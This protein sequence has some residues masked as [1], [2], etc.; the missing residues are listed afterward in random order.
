[1]HR[2]F[3]LSLFSAAAVLSSAATP[4]VAAEDDPYADWSVT[5]LVGEAESVL[6]QAKTDNIGAESRSRVVYLAAQRLAKS[7]QPHRAR[8][9]FEKG[10]QLSPWQIE[11][12]LDYAD[13]LKTL[14]ED[15][16][17]RH[18][19]EHVVELSETEELR[20]R[21]AEWLGVAPEPPLTVLDD[22]LIPLGRPAICIIPVGKPP[23][24]LVN[25]CGY[26]LSAILGLE[27][28][29]Y[30]D[31]IALPPSNRSALRRWANQVGNDIHWDHPD[32][33][34][35]MGRL[36][37]RPNKERIIS[38]TDV[39][40]VMEAILQD[41]GTP[42]QLG[43][44]RKAWDRFKQAGQDEQ[45]DAEKLREHVLAGLGKETN[46]SILWVALTEG[47]LYAGDNNYLFGLAGSPPAC[48]VVS[49]ARFTAAFNGEP[50]SARRLSE[51]LLKQLLSSVGTL[52][53]ADRSLDPTCPRSYPNGLQQHDAKGLKLCERCRQMISASIR[54]PL[55]EAPA[56]PFSA[57]AKK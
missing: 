49:C 36:D 53:G 9:F 50:P 55:P 6:N 26:A 32:I 1:M 14:H 18:W 33:A 27:V 43:N 41:T 42:E 56:D 12:Y 52:L 30:P 13:V 4:L 31:R 23:M 15:I 47:D 29:R 10:L 7:E 35:I 54:Q 25:R 22:R 2:R 11:F 51:R 38:S 16:E 20:E 37:I 40:R 34:R 21:A 24:W 45:W 46:R 28:F 19:A 8:Q 3:F 17:A 39:L 44:F 48:A 5:Q 57:P